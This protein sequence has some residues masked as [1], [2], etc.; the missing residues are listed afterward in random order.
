MFRAFE[1][2][3]D[4]K[5]SDTAVFRRGADTDI[6]EQGVGVGPAPSQQCRRSDLCIVDSHTADDQ[7]GIFTRKKGP[8]QSTVALQPELFDERA[9][10]VHECTDKIDHASL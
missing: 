1:P 2:F 6:D 9:R 8:R 3:C 7:N 10:F 4:Q 5:A